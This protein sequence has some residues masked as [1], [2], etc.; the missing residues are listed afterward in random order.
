LEEQKNGSKITNR[1]ISLESNKSGKSAGGTS[2][3][4]LENN[5][6]KK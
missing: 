2:Y 4:R 1:T 6:Q 5:D 3:E